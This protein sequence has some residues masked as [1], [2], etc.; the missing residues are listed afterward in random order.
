[1]EGWRI[2]QGEKQKGRDAN[3]GMGG[4]RGEVREDSDAKNQRGELRKDGP[5]VA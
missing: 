2:S 5:D 3:A 1:V 4:K